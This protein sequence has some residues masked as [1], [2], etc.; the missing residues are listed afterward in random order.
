MRPSGMTADVTHSGPWEGRPAAQQPQW[1]DHAA[2]HASCRT[3]ESAAPLVAAEEIRQLRWSLAEL[4]ATGAL[5]LQLG[6]CAESLYEC[7]PRHT[8]QKLQVIDRLGNRFSELTGRRVLRVG[9]MA[10]QFAKPRSQPTENHGTLVIP[11]FRGHMINSELAVEQTRQPDP[12]RMV[13]AYEAS[14][15][16]QRAMRTHRR[17]DGPWSSHEALVVDYES[18][19]VRRDP[20][21]DELYL[22]STH[23]PWAGERTRRPEQPCPG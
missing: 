11:S 20:D 5:L 6:D 8:A 19:L 18:R 16:V 7:T 4:L 14:A 23:L 15:A 3:L 21:T 2:Y 22:S 10:G 12:R 1:R 17:A 9:R 13:W